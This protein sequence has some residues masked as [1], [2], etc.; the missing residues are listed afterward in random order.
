MSTLV[1]I[2]LP[3]Y[4]VEKYLERCI[5]SV[6]NQTYRNLEIIIVDDGSTDGSSE[7]SKKWQDKDSRIKV[8]RKANA[9]LGMARN[10]GIEN[11]TGE[12]MF[13]LDSDDYVSTDLV[14]KCIK[15]QKETSA[16]VVL[17]GFSR[18]DANNQVYFSRVPHTEVDRLA[19]SDINDEVLPALIASKGKKI[20]GLWM[21]AWACMY[22]KDLIDK[23]NWKF[24]SEREIIA[25]DV[26][27][28]LQ[29]YPNVKNVAVVEES[30]YFYCDNGASLTHVVRPDR[31]DKINYFFDKT[32]ELVNDIGYP[33]R[34][35]NCICSLYFSFLIAALKMVIG[36][37]EV[38]Y[39]EKRKQILGCLK[40]RE[41]KL[42]LK[43][44]TFNRKRL[45]K[46]IMVVLMRLRMVDMI[47]MM[48]KV[49]TKH[50]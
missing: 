25:E 16:D 47:Y 35:Y 32:S 8:I 6:V 14:E 20:S 3:V 17:Y 41:C 31:I 24:V 34:V 2:V 15:K 45:G 27:S 13:F 33:K 42:A 29:Y 39:F 10:T 7:I 48:L 37:T 4:N 9:G 21:S 18:V 5:D 50:I 19:G 38:G 43:N 46:S 22:S 12:Y 23:N 1:S 49:K 40:S 28:L 30:L 44:S 11:A 36:N 26:Y